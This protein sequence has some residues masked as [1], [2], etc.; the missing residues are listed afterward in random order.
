LN[1]NE[2]TGALHHC[3]KS[4]DRGSFIFTSIVLVFPY[5][6]I[7]TRT[8]IMIGDRKSCN[9]EHPEGEVFTNE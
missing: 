7:K 1:Y 2:I 8:P 9:N 4:E 6:T 3:E 5:L